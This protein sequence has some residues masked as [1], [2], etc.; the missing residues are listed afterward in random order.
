MKLKKFNELV[1]KAKKYNSYSVEYAQSVM[2]A[3]GDLDTSIHDI[4][5]AIGYARVEIK[6]R[7]IDDLMYLLANNFEYEELEKELFKII[8]KIV[9]VH[10]EFSKMYQLDPKQSNETFELLT[11]HLKTHL[12]TATCLNSVV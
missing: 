11:N 3:E 7:N 9:E 12:F 5:L 8:S 10:I 2:Y 6:K 4:S 1:E